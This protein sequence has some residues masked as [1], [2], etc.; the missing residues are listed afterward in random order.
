MVRI[1]LSCFRHRRESFAYLVSATVGETATLS[2]TVIDVNG[3]D[4]PLAEGDILC[5]VEAG[6]RQRLAEA[7]RRHVRGHVV[8]V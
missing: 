2:A 1:R 7:S 6:T 4:F 5:R 8:T 3:H